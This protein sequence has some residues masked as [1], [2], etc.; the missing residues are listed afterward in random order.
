MGYAL[1]TGTLCNPWNRT[2][3]FILRPMPAMSRNYLLRFCLPIACIIAGWPLSTSA[4]SYRF[5]HYTQEEGLPTASISQVLR[6]K[7][8][9]F[10]LL[11]ESDLVRFDGYD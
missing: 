6:D 4:Q 1:A 3:S 5:T 2:N 9:Y 7:T 8:G 11:S 10:W